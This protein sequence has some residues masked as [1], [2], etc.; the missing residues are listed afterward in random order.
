MAIKNTKESK[1]MDLTKQYM[2]YKM[3]FELDP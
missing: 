1:E 2:T 3:V